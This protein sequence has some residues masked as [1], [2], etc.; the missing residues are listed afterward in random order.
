MDSRHQE[1]AKPAA[2]PEKGVKVLTQQQLDKLKQRE[3][4][5]QQKVEAQQSRDRAETEL[6]D[7]QKN[8]IFFI[9]IININCCTS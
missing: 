9:N 1:R 8:T 6:H 7:I 5:Q 2:D 3:T 4:L